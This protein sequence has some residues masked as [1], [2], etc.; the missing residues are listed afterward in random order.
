MVLARPP[1]ARV[2]AVA[3]RTRG[4]LVGAAAR[5]VVDRRPVRDRLDVLLRRPVPR[6][7]AARRLGRRRDGLLRRL[8]LLHVGRRAPVAG[9]DQRGPRPRSPPRN[10]CACS[11][12]SR[13]AS[14]GGAA[15]SSSSE[16]ST[17]TSRPSMRCR[18]GSTPAR[19]D[20]LVWKPDAL[21]SV[22]FLVSGYLAYAEV[23]GHP[24]W[25]RNRT[26]EWK[27]AAVNLVGCIAFGISAVASFWVPTP[28]ACSPWPHRT[29]SRRSVGSASSSARCSCCRNPPPPKPWS[30]AERRC[31]L[32]R[33]VRSDRR[34]RARR[35]RAGLEAPPRRPDRVLDRRARP[36]A[37]SCSTC[38]A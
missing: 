18:P 22:C 12:S 24:F 28:A 10:A 37:R 20:R 2:E 5:V 27:I 33:D 26:L 31:T 35:A 38:S 17:S 6:L 1:Q 19:Y 13:A 3:A 15:A 23:C 36:A 7:R 14:T 21:G 11:R 32:T 34:S 25:T 29:G 8:D 9:D 16:P 4:R 30:P